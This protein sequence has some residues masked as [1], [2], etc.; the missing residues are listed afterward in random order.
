MGASTVGAGTVL[1]MAPEL[2]HRDSKYD[3]KVDVFSYAMCLI[4]LVS[5]ERPWQGSGVRQEAIPVQLLEGERP[6]RQLERADE[7][8]RRLI[9]DCWDNEPSSRPAFSDIVVRV[10]EMAGMNG[11]PGATTASRPASPA[12]S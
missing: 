7:C 5:H 6:E 9:E 3:E 2:F 1:W 4:E 8:M 11:S 10:A 12:R